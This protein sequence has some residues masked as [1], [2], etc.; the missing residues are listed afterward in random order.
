[1]P[2]Y[3]KKDTPKISIVTCTYNGERIIKDYLEGIFLQDYPIK[4]MEII[5]ADGGSTDRT[6]EII[7][8]YQTNHPKLIKL[9]HN[10]KKVS[11]GKGNGMDMA[12]RLA[13]G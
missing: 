12:T 13:K 8:S 6:K 9:I 1:M 4:D 10:P 11:I 3:L 7:S 2:K 5:L